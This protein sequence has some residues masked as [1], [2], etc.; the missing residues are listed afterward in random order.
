MLLMTVAG[1]NVDGGANGAD[2]VDDVKTKE[3]IVDLDN[4]DDIYF[5][6]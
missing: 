4:Y 3:E 2:D 5:I 6:R 1:E